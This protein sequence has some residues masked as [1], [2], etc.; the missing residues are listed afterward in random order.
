M[1][2]AVKNIRNIGGGIAFLKTWTDGMVQVLLYQPSGTIQG[3]DTSIESGGSITML[4]GPT[5]MPPK[6]RTAF[7]VY[8][9]GE[10][11]PPDEDLIQA[12]KDYRRRNGQDGFGYPILKIAPAPSIG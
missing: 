1:E 12:V 8:N 2:N 10:T 6:K 9:L 7:K 4:S 3:K 5:L 11:I